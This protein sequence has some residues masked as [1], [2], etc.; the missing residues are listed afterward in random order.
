MT[1]GEQNT[2]QEAHEQLDYAFDQGINFLDAA[3]MYPVPPGEKTQGRTE[4]Y[5]GNWMQK[6]KR[7][8][9]VLA[10]KVRICAA[11]SMSQYLHIIVQDCVGCRQMHV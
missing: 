6:R 5:I 11:I 10:T 8:D 3:E 2:E 4:Q 9:V 1:W 7:E